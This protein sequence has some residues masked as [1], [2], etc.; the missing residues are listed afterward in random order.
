MSTAFKTDLYSHFSTYAGLTAYV[1]KRIKPM[2]LTQDLENPCLGYQVISGGERIHSHQGFSNLER[3][4]LQV[5][6]FA[7][8]ALEAV[9]IA[10]QVI[11]AAQAWGAANAKVQRAWVPVTPGDG[12]DDP[13]GC[14]HIPV[15][16][17]VIYG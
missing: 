4:N 12:Y 3:F 17:S 14:V 5:S 10:D 16:I 9:Q 2:E 7:D 6:V 1:G 8:D 13:T 15:D 11:L